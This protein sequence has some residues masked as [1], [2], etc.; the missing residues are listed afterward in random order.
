MNWIERLFVRAKHWQIFL[1]FVLLG[2][3]SEFPVLGNFAA[4]VK[5]P[6]GYGAVLIL[7]EVL[8]AMAVWCFLLWL[9]SAGSFL[10]AVAPAPLRLKKKFF[11]FTVL[12]TAIYVPVSIALFQSINP[13]LFVITI[14]VHLFA[15]FCMFYNLYFVAEGLVIAEIRKRPSFFDCAGPFFLIWFFLIGVWFIQPRIN[16]LYAEKRSA[17][18]TI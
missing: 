12:F 4:A 13:K 3:I 8:T 16:R 15:V 7:T 18:A 5:S 6:E 17:E 10:T 14:P 2:A 11:S 9:W 1:L